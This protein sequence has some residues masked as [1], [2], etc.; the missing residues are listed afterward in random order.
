MILDEDNEN[1]SRLNERNGHTMPKLLYVYGEDNRFLDTLLSSLRSNGYSVEYTS[2]P[3]DTEKSRIMADVAL[4]CKPVSASTKVTIGNLQIDIDNLIA[5][6]NGE[7]VHF[8]PTEFS[9][10][11]YLLK[12][13][14]RAVP[15]SELLPAVWGFSN[16]SETRVADDTVKRLRKKLSGTGVE[17]DTIWGYGFKIREGKKEA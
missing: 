16:S 7:T 3:N 17:I 15:R 5:T 2:I 6:H 10:L 8:T 14:S 11:T 4:I 13:S 9:M 1:N 12:N